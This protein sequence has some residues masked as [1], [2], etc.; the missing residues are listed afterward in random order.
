MTPQLS[1]Y[2][3]LLRFAA[4]SLVFISH[5]CWPTLGGYFGWME[6]YGH[7][8][9]ILF[10][11]LSGYV[12]AYTADRRERDARSFFVHRLARLWSVVLP[13]L[14]F[15]SIADA[16]GMALDPSIYNLANH[17]QPLARILLAA[18][19]TNE[20]WGWRAMPLS[21]TPF[22]SLPYEFWAYVFF[23]LFAFGRGSWRLPA[24]G[25][26]ALA[27]GP[28]ILLYLP[29]W[30][31]GVALYRLRCHRLDGHRGLVVFLAT[32]IL[33]L[34]LATLSAHIRGDGSTWLPEEFSLLDYPLALFMALH[35]HAAAAILKT[36]P[37][38]VVRPI[39]F[40]AGRTF[41]LYLFHVPLLHLTA[42]A[43]VGLP[44]GPLKA[45][46]VALG[47]LVPVPLLALIS[48]DRKAGYRRLLMRM[49]AVLRPAASEVA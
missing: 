13:A 24:A 7:T 43:L 9:V 34:G 11:I 37:R 23:G 33:G 41:S 47:G 39:R 20:L 8:G 42:A 22:W 18:T 19:F 15:V 21:A 45:C 10:L 25:V 3:D 5:L 1:L 2:L 6:P 35:I 29:I 44:H 16:I 26:L 30:L 14:I 40:A 27:L 32:P 4:A 17:A 46:L 12:I 36:W 31:L 49:L 38:I 28:K 48:E